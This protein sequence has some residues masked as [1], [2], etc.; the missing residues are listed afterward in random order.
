VTLGRSS[1]LGR[2]SVAVRAT[3]DRD[4]PD[5]DGDCEGATAY[6]TVFDRYAFHAANDDA[7][8]W[9]ATTVNGR[10]ARLG[11]LR[12]V[13]G[14][15]V[16]P[17]LAWEFAPGRWALVQG[18]TPLG[19]APEALHTVAAALQPVDSLPILVPFR[20]GWLPDLTVTSCFYDP[21]QEA[22]AGLTLVDNGGRTLTA[23][24]RNSDP[25]TVSHV[26]SH[27]VTVAGIAGWYDRLN[28]VLDVR[29]HDAW[30]EIDLSQVDP[31]TFSNRP[32]TA[33]DRADLDR[34]VAG[35]S[36]TGVDGRA[37]FVPLGQSVP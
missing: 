3:A 28:G 4:Y 35:V 32:L 2:R 33:L 7:A 20:F 16:V 22:S 37:P 26:P 15:E 13:N 31:V 8:G 23:Y 29:L 27:R 10:P 18:L 36:F 1:E 17:S 25:G 12:E 19:K 6:V 9:A 5:C 30:L 21:S 34:V 11:R 14:T 24:V